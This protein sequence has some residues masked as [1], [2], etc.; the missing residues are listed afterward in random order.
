MKK[1][2][3]EKE[4]FTDDTER[5]LKD[6]AEETRKFE[7]QIE[8][9]SDLLREIKNA[10]S[11]SSPT[12]TVQCNGRVPR[13]KAM[14]VVQDVVSRSGDDGFTLT[15]V[16]EALERAELSVNANYIHKT[17]SRLKEREV[18]ESVDGK[19]KYRKTS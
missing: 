8:C 2:Q 19:G 1:L 12:P 4:H 6:R 7:W 17:I 3:S 18:V 5:I 13:G 15:E 11:G 16:K 14:F 10:D 9:C